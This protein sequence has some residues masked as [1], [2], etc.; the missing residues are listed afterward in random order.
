MKHIDPGSWSRREHFSVYSGFAN[1]HFG[2]CAN[3]DVGTLRRHAKRSGISFTVAVVY[4]LARTA[5]AIPE[6]RRR[7]REEKVVEHSIVH[8]SITVLARDDLFSFCMI[9]YAD[10]FSVFA[11]GAREMIAR[12]KEYPT[13]E[14]EPGRDDLLFMTAI[15]WVSFTAFSHP[16]PAPPVDSVPR[17]AWG[18]FF[19]NGKT[20]Q[21]PLAV[22]AHHAIMDGIHMGRFYKRAQEYMAKPEIIIC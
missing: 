10:D 11:T 20:L 6:F 22:Q 8:P 2:L 7:I 21:M 1:P 18:R 16:M 3:V 19:D 17:I 14:D 13:L 5:N 15:P 9:E 4:T 12:A